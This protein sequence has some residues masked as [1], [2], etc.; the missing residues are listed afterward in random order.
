ML[1]C[2]PY[3]RTDHTSGSGLRFNA[4]AAMPSVAMRH[5]KTERVEH[6]DCVADA[7]LARVESALVAL[8]GFEAVHG[9]IV[10]RSEQRERWVAAP[11]SSS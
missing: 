6:R 10:V 9:Q 5:H 1:L 11:R 7:P 2:A 3:S 4:A 8:L